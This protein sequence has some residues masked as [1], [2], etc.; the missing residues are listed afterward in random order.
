LFVISE[1]GIENGAQVKPL[2]EAGVKALLVGE[3][4]VKNG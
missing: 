3:S 4:L 1:S 2:K